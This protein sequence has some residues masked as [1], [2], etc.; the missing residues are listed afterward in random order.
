MIGRWHLFETFLS[1]KQTVVNLFSTA[2][3]LK[4][5]GH[6]ASSTTAADDLPVAPCCVSTPY[7]QTEKADRE[8][9][10]EMP[11]TK[12]QN[13]IWLSWREP[14]PPGRSVQIQSAIRRKYSASLT[15]IQMG[16][17]S[18]FLFVCLF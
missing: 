7:T 15:G 2:K 13:K 17:R 6:F 10:S 4:T 1:T 3:G 5:R 16:N 12:K 8:G 14:Q 11:K 9:D 18:V